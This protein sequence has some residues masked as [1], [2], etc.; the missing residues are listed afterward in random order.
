MTPYIYAQSLSKTFGD[1]VVLHN[2]SFTIAQGEILA[3]TGNSGCGKTTL[4]NILGLLDSPTSGTLYLRDQVYPNINSKEA[5]LWRRST[6][7]YIFQSFALI[8]S[9]T[10]EDNL[11]LALNY[12]KLKKKERLE[13]ARIILNHFSIAEKMNHKVLELS[14]GEKQRVAIARAILKPG[15]LILADE[16]TG[17]LDGAMAHKVMDLLIYATKQTGKT[18]VVVTHDMAMTKKCDRILHIKDGK[19]FS[20]NK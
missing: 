15:N 12:T 20:V 4:L 14:G 6:I 18:L 9:W 8:D 7:N 13:R 1:H 5:T 10:V 2:L 16:P 3:I 19:I 17:S 11:L